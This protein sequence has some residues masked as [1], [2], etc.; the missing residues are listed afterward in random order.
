MTKGIADMMKVNGPRAARMARQ[1]LA[2]EEDEDAI[3]ERRLTGSQ[4]K[5]AVKKNRR[6]VIHW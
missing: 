5:G 1:G 6:V 4:V 2:T 3:A